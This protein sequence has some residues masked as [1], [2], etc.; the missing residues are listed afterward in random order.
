M[1]VKNDYQ[2]SKK[3]RVGPTQ[4]NPFYCWVRRGS[5]ARYWVGK[6]ENWFQWFMSLRITDCSLFLSELGLQC[7]QM[8]CGRTPCLR[9]IVPAYLRFRVTRCSPSGIT[10]VSTDSSFLSDP[11]LRWLSTNPK[12][13]LW[14]LWR[15]ISR[16]RYLPMSNCTLPYLE[17]QTR[18]V[19][20]CWLRDGTPAHHM[21]VRHM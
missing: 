21:V 12:I 13:R 5:Q 4:K 6:E 19:Y 11:P 16:N 2:C 14:K 9:T 18:A 8:Y 3:K 20:V 15:S 17:W 7:T 10:L 1:L